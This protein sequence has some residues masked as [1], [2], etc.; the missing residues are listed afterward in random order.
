[1][2]LV[3]ALVLLGGAGLG[4]RALAQHGAWAEAPDPQGAMRS[5]AAVGT[6]FTYQGRLTDG[7]GKPLTGAYDFE[8]RLYDGSGGG[9][10][11]IG[12]DVPV[13][14][15]QVDEGLFTVTLDFGSDAFTGEAR[16]LEVRVREGAS[17]GGFTQLLPR[18]EL[19]PA[20]YALGL[21]PGAAVKGTLNNTG[22]LSLTN[23]ADDGLRVEEAGDDGVQVTSASYGFYL[24]DASADG[25]LIDSVGNDGVRVGSAG[26]D[27]VQVDSADYGIFVSSSD[28]DCIYA[29]N[30]DADGDGIG[31]AGFFNG[32]VRVTDHLTATNLYAVNKNFVIDHPL[33]PENKLLYHS[34]VESPD[35]LNVYN[36]NTVLDAKGEAWVELPDYF[37]ALN[38]D[39]RYQLTPIGGAA[40]SLHVAEEIQANR[41]RIAGGEPG[42]KVS[43]QVTGIRDDASARANPMRVEVDKAADRQGLYI[44]PEAYGQPR[45]MGI[46]LA[47][48]VGKGIIR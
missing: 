5:Q 40:P 28:T 15:K 35:R 25:L 2:A 16:W 7:G 42:L 29:G 24:R 34:S 39:F 32:D 33:D 37:E 27:G 19:T 44:D 45:S 17:T 22:V 31:L 36:G 41:F 14:D 3:A 48:R 9:A 47:E 1:M 26:G 8:F 23:P 46:D 21:M 43:W 18:Q 20:P 4:L 10:N 12:G 38:R 6:T 13:N 11:Q 30:A